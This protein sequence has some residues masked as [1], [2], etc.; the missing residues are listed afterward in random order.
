MYYIT[1]LKVLCTLLIGS[2]HY[3]TL[4]LFSGLFIN[5]DAIIYLQLCNKNRVT[6]GCKK[7]VNTS[8]LISQEMI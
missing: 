8:P 7:K 2:L 1:A 5:V 4:H 3:N 6:K